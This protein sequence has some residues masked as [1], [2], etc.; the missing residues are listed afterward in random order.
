L[1]AAY[2]AHRHIHANPIRRIGNNS[3]NLAQGR[4]YLSA[5]AEGKACNRLFAQLFAFLDSNY[6]AG[7]GF[8][9]SIIFFHAR[10]VHIHHGGKRG[11]VLFSS[12]KRSTYLFFSVFMSPP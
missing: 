9:T 3:I 11:A 5:I 10:L 6:P 4:Q 8:K 2:F 12:S 1:G 7:V